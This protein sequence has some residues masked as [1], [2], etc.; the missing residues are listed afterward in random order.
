MEGII[1]TA[2][3][4]IH[5][6]NFMDKVM[7][8]LVSRVAP[9]MEPINCIKYDTTNPQVFLTTCGL[10]NGD[11]KLYTSAT[12]DQIVSFPQYTL[13]PVKFITTTPLKNRGR[14][15]IIGHE[16]GILKFIDITNLKVVGIYQVALDEGETLTCGAFNNTGHNFAIGTSHGSVFLGYHKKDSFNKYNTFLSRVTT[17]SKTTENAV[18][19]VNLS[20]FTPY[21]S[22]LVAFD[23]G[24]VRIWQ[25]SI[26]HEQYI[27]LM[28]MRGMN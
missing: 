4:N 5:Y 27:K 2:E 24:I 19:S 3:G 26:K 6:I 15:R 1:G 16:K 28:E 18:T 13:G 20:Q 21:G 9:V 8:K 17:V 22:L 25:S 23:N 11:V 12:V 14:V 10:T 7:V